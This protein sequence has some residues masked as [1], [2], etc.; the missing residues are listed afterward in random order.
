M[1]NLKDNIKEELKNSKKGKPKETG[2]VYIKHTGGGTME[3]E[4]EGRES[5]I[6]NLFLNGIENTFGTPELR[7]AF[8]RGVEMVYDNWD[9]EEAGK[10]KPEFFTGR[11]V[12]LMSKA[13]WWTD[14]K[15]YDV[16]D[17]YI[18]DDDGD[19]NGPFESADEMC[20]LLAG[21]FYPIT[22]D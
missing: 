16:I 1:D 3:L 13:P 18:T 6:L 7:K 10:T 17:G 4:V 22:E 9:L 15:L 5:T 2:L 12:C 20:D 19:E 8:K 21:D 14:G 11:V